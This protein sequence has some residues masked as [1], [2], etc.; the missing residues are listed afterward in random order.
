VQSRPLEEP[1]M[2]MRWPVMDSRGRSINAPKHR[3][4]HGDFRCAEFRT[5]LDRPFFAIK[6]PQKGWLMTNLHLKSDPASCK[7]WRLPHKRN[8]YARRFLGAGWADLALEFAAGGPREHGR[9]AVSGR[10]G[11]EDGLAQQGVHPIVGIHHLG[12]TEVHPRADQGQGFA[13]LHA[14]NERRR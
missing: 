9:V 4:L 12:H 7:R 6:Q 10:L 2:H 11:A 5:S 1:I 8:G 3:N 14:P 13:L